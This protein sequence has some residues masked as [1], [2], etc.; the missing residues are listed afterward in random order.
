MTEL[1]AAPERLPRR[2]GAIV[3]RRLDDYVHGQWPAL[4]RY[5][6]ALCGDAS[7][8]EEIVQAALVRVAVRWPFVRDKDHPDGY[9]RRAI[10]H[11]FFNSRR[12]I[13]GRETSMADVPEQLSPD[14]TAG[15]AD[16]VAVRRALLTLPPRQR[17]VLVL[18]YLEDRSEHE[19]ADLLGCSVGTVKSQTSKGLAKLREAVGLTLDDAVDGGNR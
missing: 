5:A 7:E 9:V 15:V 16:H 8:A 19:T 18:R 14:S 13:R 3:D 17:A 4:V 11:G 1:I 12:R 10:V 2:K 6:T